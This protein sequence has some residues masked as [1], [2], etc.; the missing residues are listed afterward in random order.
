MNV[1]PNSFRSK[2]FF[3]R[4]YKK[5]PNYRKIAS[6]DFETTNLGDERYEDVTF[7]IVGI[8]WSVENGY[9]TKLCTS[10]EEVLQEM[11]SRPEYEYYAHNLNFDASVMLPNLMEHV[12]K[13]KWILKPLIRGYTN[14]FGLI[15]QIPILNPDGTQKR[16]KHS[17][18][19]EKKTGKPQYEY[20]TISWYDSFA[21]L[22][23]SLQ[24]ASKAM[25]IE[26]GKQDIG[27]KDGEEFDVNNPIHIEYLQYDL[28][29]TIEIVQA[30]Q[31]QYWQVFN[32][33]VGKT[34]SSSAIKA[35]QAHLPEGHAYP[36]QH[37]HVIDF[38]RQGVYGGC[39]T[40]AST[41]EILRKVGC[42]D[43]KGAYGG[44][45]LDEEFGYGNP[46]EVKNYRPNEF[47]FYKCIVHAHD[48]YPVGLLPYRV[49][50]NGIPIEIIYPT[51]CTFEGVYSS[52]QIDFARKKGYEIEIEY[53]F[54]YPNR[55][56]VFEEFINLCYEFETKEGGI[57]KPVAK[58]GR[59][60][61]FG[62]T[63]EKQIQTGVYVFPDGPD[64][65]EYY[66]LLDQETGYPIEGI[67]LK[68]EISERQ[69]HQVQWGGFITAC[70]QTRLLEYATTMYDLYGFWPYMDTD[71]IKAPIEYIEGMIQKGLM[72]VRD[73]S[74]EASYGELV[75]EGIAEY[76]RCNG[77]KDYDMLLIDPSN[78]K[79][80]KYKG[81]SKGIP[82]K[83]IYKR[84]ENLWAQGADIDD[85]LPL[86]RENSKYDTIGVHSFVSR[87]K[88]PN[89]KIDN[90]IKDKQRST[91]QSSSR[92][93]VDEDGNVKSRSLENTA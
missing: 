34:A 92:W 59:N 56:K 47:G 1:Y 23:M 19:Q 11:I 62:K 82:Q 31:D 53:G 67:Y 7:K 66:P 91:L 15:I 69:Y 10:I 84:V 3:R 79:G 71:S 55:E 22:P 40:P 49:F 58:Q 16:T 30:Y 8:S 78:H 83:E 44:V 21:L 57:Y 52:I 2:W 28:M 27:L 33:K 51:A 89:F 39:T 85:I 25:R 93:K 90:P 14:L 26:H 18:R 63:I 6:I 70:Q 68:D 73:T 87:L 60:S 50:K 72:V 46:V 12:R 43:M 36:P 20:K 65:D 81:G 24:A 64:S 13:D 38:I 86:L 45:M 61:A 42:V 29:A 5:K 77:P 48:K 74:N 76:F 54:Y 32:S 41:T 37:K 4:E 17:A 35:L 80:Y 88:H 9:E 75:D